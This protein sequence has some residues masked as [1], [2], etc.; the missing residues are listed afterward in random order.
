MEK[1]WGAMEHHICPSMGV[2]FKNRYE[3]VEIQTDVFIAHRTIRGRSCP[4]GWDDI[5]PTTTR[6]NVEA[7]NELVSGA[8]S[9]ARRHHAWIQPRPSPIF[10]FCMEP[11]TNGGGP[12][13]S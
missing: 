9:K 4:K 2:P 1:P 3:H 13:G 12:R 8:L 10:L 5:S 6:T 7:H 11:L